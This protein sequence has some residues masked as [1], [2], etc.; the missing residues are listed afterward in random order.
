MDRNN[1]SESMNC[2]LMHKPSFWKLVTN[3]NEDVVK[4]G[5]AFPNKFDETDA[6][7]SRLN[8]R[9]ERAENIAKKKKAGVWKVEEL[10]FFEKFSDY[11]PANPLTR[12]FRK[13][14]P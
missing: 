13:R 3:I 5:L 11:I 9:L 10:S 2:I 14:S 12:F 1:D 7:W 8:K 6:V 4:K